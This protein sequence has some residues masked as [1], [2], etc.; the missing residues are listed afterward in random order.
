MDWEL[1]RGMFARV[2]YKGDPSPERQGWS[3]PWSG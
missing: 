2:A 1:T 3:E